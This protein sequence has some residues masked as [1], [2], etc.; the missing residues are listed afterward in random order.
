MIEIEIVSRIYE[1]L[2]ENINSLKTIN[3]F[4]RV[5]FYIISTFLFALLITS[6]IKQI[7]VW[8]KNR[9]EKSSKDTSSAVYEQKITIQNSFN[10]SNAVNIFIGSNQDA[11]REVHNTEIK[12]TTALGKDLVV[13]MILIFILLLLK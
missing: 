2:I 3:S 12:K 13:L 1:V 7:I 10:N 8:F 4:L 6:K 11:N 5:I 9:K